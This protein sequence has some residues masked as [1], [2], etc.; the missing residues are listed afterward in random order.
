MEILFRDD[1]YARSCEATVTAVDE[2]GI[3][4]DRTVFYP[5]GG[6][7]PGDCG[8]LRSPE[9]D[10]EIVNAVKG[11][12]PD[13]V[14]HVPAEGAAPPAVGNTVTAELD[15]ERR[16]RLM[17]MHTCMH[18]LSA[19]L[20]YPVTGGQVSDGKGRLDFDI[21]EA[22][23]DKEEIAAELNKLISA[24]HAVTAEWI[25]DAELAAQP[26][27]VK[28]M[29]VKPPTGAGQ[30]RLIRIGDLDLQPCGGTH[31]ARSGEI[32]PVVVRKIQKK[33]RLNRRVSLAFAD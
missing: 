4:L 9:G 12:G 28:T 20:S 1:A 16:H 33:G 21:P 22:V 8:N 11:D 14:I 10:V 23:L 19:V 25:S 32:G 31:I 27:L 5:T 17:R 29:S 18:L 7:Q 24:D 26:E 15:W 13:G 2:R 30:V 6:G 3:Q